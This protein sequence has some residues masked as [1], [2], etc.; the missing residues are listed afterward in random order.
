MKKCCFA[1]HSEIYSD[2][3]LICNMVKNKAEELITK[4]NVKEFWAGN[5]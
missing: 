2:K 5:Y 3:D 1:G 4:E